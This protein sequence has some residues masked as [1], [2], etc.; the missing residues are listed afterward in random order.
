MLSPLL[1]CVSPAGSS[2]GVGDVSPPG[3]QP[4]LYSPAPKGAAGGTGCGDGWDATAEHRAPVVPGS[5][6]LSRRQSRGVGPPT[7]NGRR[8][9]GQGGRK[10]CLGELRGGG[11]FTLVPPGV[12]SESVPRL[13]TARPLLGPCGDVTRAP[14]WT[15]AWAPHPPTEPLSLQNGGGLSGLARVSVPMATLGWGHDTSGGGV[16][17]TSGDV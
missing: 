1:G 17:D 12:G 13:G 14:A 5:L 6:P 10:P 4:G 11:V 9:L 8:C 3:P 2:P 16:S 7:Q 15:Q